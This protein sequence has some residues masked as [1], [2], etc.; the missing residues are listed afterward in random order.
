MHLYI[1]TII[2]VGWIGWGRLMFA[3]LGCVFGYA[4]VMG[5]VRDD[6]ILGGDGSLEG[7]ATA[8]CFKHATL[9]C[10]EPD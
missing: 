3:I 8:R 7:S 5:K 4:I 2:L 10:N 1:G 6:C 9:N